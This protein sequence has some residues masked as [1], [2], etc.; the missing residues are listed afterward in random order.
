MDLYLRIFRRGVNVIIQS[1]HCKQKENG[2]SNIFW[3]NFV[4][5]MKGESREDDLVESIRAALTSFD[6]AEKFLVLRKSDM[7]HL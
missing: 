1:K 2:F 5:V 3:N 7:S 4:D 6:S